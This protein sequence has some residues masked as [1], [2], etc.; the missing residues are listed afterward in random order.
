M[1]GMKSQDVVVLLKPV[2]L[3]QQE[4]ETGAEGI[5]SHLGGEA[6]YSVRGLESQLGI[7][8]TEIGASFKRIL[9]NGMAIK[10]RTTGRPKAHRRNLYDFIVH[11][12][13][14]VFPV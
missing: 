6:H 5:R 4:E 3:Q 1:S 8:K 13:K 10:D 2:S 12:L 14:F 11:G 9:S 7:S